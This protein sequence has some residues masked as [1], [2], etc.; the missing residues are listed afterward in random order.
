MRRGRR[1]PDRSKGLA[2]A[3]AVTR[4][5][6]ATPIIGEATLEVEALEGVSSRQLMSYVETKVGK[7]YVWSESVAEGVTS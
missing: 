4:E 5:P 3:G 6:G 1:P 7:K 2:G